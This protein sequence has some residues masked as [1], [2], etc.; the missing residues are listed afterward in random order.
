MLRE[1]RERALPSLLADVLPYCRFLGIELAR[2]GEGVIATMR[3]GEH[4]I[5]DSSI[6][7]LHGGAICGLLETTA[8]FEVLWSVPNVTFP[9][10]ITLTIDYLRSGRPRDTRCRAS[11]VRLGRRIAVVAA[12]AYQDDA[13]KPIAT[14]IVHVLV[15]EEGAG[16]DG[17][18]NSAPGLRARAP[19]RCPRS[20]TPRP[21][22]RVRSF[23]RRGSSR[24]HA[25]RSPRR[26]A[27][28]DPRAPR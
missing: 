17:R 21:R 3:Y 10:T 22:A 12:R 20:A 19:D 8:M 27:H 28:R 6:P 18:E 9:K 16:A 2:D 15:E 7:A 11:I 13:R 25:P 4:L 5:G 1:A 23:R 24:S 14:A 26:G